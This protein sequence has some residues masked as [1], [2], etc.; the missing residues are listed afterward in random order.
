MNAKRLETILA[1]E[2]AAGEAEMV[3]RFQKLRDSGLLPISRGRNAQQIS[4]DQI[5]SGLLSV[6]SHRPGNA[7]VV[8]T[9]L[10]GLVP[11]G[12]PDTAF[13]GA[14]TMAQALRLALGDPAVLDSMLEIRLTDSEVYANAPGRAALFY[15]ED[16]TE[17]VTYYVPR[18]ATP[19]L[20][21]GAEQTYDPM[22]LP[23]PI[24]RETVIAPR[25][26]SQIASEVARDEVQARAMAETQ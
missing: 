23:S 13:A 2:F 15:L 14:V 12:G 17:Q 22:D 16:D 3:Q 20:R 4:R 25:L 6:V 26:L 1:S 21:P 19:L 11:V 7:G 9:M 24:I 8:A 18:T 5:A 10:R